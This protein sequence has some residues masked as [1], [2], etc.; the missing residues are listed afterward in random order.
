[1]SEKHKLNSG[2]EVNGEKLEKHHQCAMCYVIRYLFFLSDLCKAKAIM[3]SLIYN[4]KIYD[5]SNTYLLRTNKSDNKLLL[6]KCNTADSLIS[7]NKIIKCI[8]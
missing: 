4:D 1:M 7:L 5:E 6:Q 3:T 8:T 2:C